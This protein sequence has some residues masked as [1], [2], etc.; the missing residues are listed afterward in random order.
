M[1]GHAPRISRNGQKELAEKKFKKLAYFSAL[2]KRLSKHHVYHASH[3]V[4]TSKKPSPTT[5]FFQ[6]P[7]QKLKKLRKFPSAS[8]TNSFFKKK[9]PTT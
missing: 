4:L 7:P 6:K 8:L 9:R 5:H 3:H 1:V 2:K